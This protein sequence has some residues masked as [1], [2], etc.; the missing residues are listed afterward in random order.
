MFRAAFGLSFF[1][2][3]FCFVLLTVTNLLPRSREMAWPHAV[4][5]LP[6]SAGGQ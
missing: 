6:K 5:L 3:V 1:C 2:F 4:S